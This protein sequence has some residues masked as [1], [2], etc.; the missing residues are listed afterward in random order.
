[1]VINRRQFLALTSGVMLLN[2]SS[3]L[4]LPGTQKILG[5]R[6][7]RAG[8]HFFSVIDQNTKTEI[9]I[10]LPQRGHGVCT[11]TEGNHAAVFARRPGDYVWVVDL[12]TQQ[13]SHKINATSQRHFYGHGVFTNDGSTLLCSENAYDEGKGVIG[14]YDVYDNFTRVG[15]F[16]SF[17]IGP[18]EIKLLSD[19]ETLVVANGGIQTHPDMPR[20]K[21]NLET[22]RA[23]LAYIDIA[24][25]RLLH[26]HELDANLHQLS[27][28]HIDISSNDSVAIAMQ[29]QG[30][31]Y[32][33]PPLIA[34]QQDRE[35]IT[36]L[37][38][39]DDIHK[40]LR[41]YCG[42]VVFG[43][44]SKIFIV[45]SPRGGLA[46]YWS[47]KG[48]YLGL[49]NQNDA[50][51]VSQSTSN[52]S[53]FLVSDGAGNILQINQDFTSVDYY[54]SHEWRWDNHLLTI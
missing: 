46:T 7:D 4:A 48:D 38:A 32:L 37:T 27:I 13:V 18:H 51:G 45:S 1:M 44:N 20:V 2:P 35:P 50:C 49:H 17:G 34:I 14:V 43:K 23:N 24:S 39:P 54:Q 40:R 28:R 6:S 33:Y 52:D 42:S 41:N 3:L 31:P 12:N 5:C 26:K 22:M 16:E 21:L 30:D 19:G 29:S 36:A 15:E 53:E 11:T 47:A 8:K 10:L 9:N 25:G